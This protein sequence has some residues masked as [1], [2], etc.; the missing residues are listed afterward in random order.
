LTFITT[1]YDS[2]LALIESLISGITDSEKIADFATDYPTIY[3]GIIALYEEII[4]EEGTNENIQEF[5]EEYPTFYKF[6]LTLIEGRLLSVKNTM[7]T[8]KSK[9][10]N[11][12]NQSFMPNPELSNNPFNDIH[13]LKWILANRNRINSESFFDAGVITTGSGPFEEDDFDNILRSLGIEIYHSHPEINTMIVGENGWSEDDI[14]AMINKEGY[15]V[16][17]QQMAL[18][19]ILFGLDCYKDFI[20]CEQLRENHPAFDYIDNLIFDWPETEIIDGD[21]VSNF[22]PATWPTE[23]LLKHMGYKVGISGI[24]F[25]KRKDILSRIFQYDIPNVISTEYMEKWGAPKTSKRLQK[26]SNSIAAFVR[27][28]KR[29]NNPVLADAIKDWER[30][31]DWLKETYFTD[32]YDFYWP[33][34]NI[35]E[36]DDGLI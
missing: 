17:T 34:P 32:N 3:N 13:I 31:L 15:K 14:I 29:K 36:Y 30:D 27:N 33:S 12:N 11:L 22:D 20:I 8:V 6:A 24:T 25:N 18:I 4:F 26:L 5:R 21:G 28:A 2:I 23:G 19:A 9:I 16:Y 10:H 35:F 7:E 1:L